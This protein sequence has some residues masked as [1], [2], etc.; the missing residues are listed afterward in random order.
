M[1]KQIAKLVE[2]ADRLDSKGMYKEADDIDDM[3]TDLS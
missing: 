3:L 2:L 1:K